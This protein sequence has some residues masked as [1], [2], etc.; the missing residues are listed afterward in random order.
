MKWSKYGI[1]VG[2]TSLAATR[3][4]L[5]QQVEPQYNKRTLINTSSG[6]ARGI[7]PATPDIISSSEFSLPPIIRVSPLPVCLKVENGAIKT[8]NF[9]ANSKHPALHGDNLMP[10]RSS[11][12]QTRALST[13]KATQAGAPQGGMRSLLGRLAISDDGSDGSLTARGDSKEAMGTVKDEASAAPSGPLTQEPSQVEVL[14]S[15]NKTYAGGRSDFTQQIRCRWTA[16]PRTSADADMGSSMPPAGLLHRADQKQGLDVSAAAAAIM[17][18]APR[19]RLH[20]KPMEPLLLGDTQKLKAPNKM[21]VSSSSP[22]DP[23]GAFLNTAHRTDAA[24]RL[25][26]LSSQLPQQQWLGTSHTAALNE[27]SSAPAGEIVQSLHP[28]CQN[29]GERDTVSQASHNT[30]DRSS[31]PA[32]LPGSRRSS[33]LLLAAASA[34]TAPSAVPVRSRAGAYYRAL[35]EQQRSSA[36]AGAERRRQEWVKGRLLDPTVCGQ[37]GNAALYL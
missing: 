18:P 11:L 7:N 17:H 10:L 20:S 6:H 16:F 2:G 35:R 34:V 36:Q 21:T 37:R 28:S 30:S 1:K 26:P 19:R 15:D 24:L 12:T 22:N 25:P 31:A 33:L 32:I 4:A 14:A 13:A 29:G 3:E 9:A 23:R 5:R 8:E 27:R